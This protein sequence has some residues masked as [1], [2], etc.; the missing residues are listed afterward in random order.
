[1]EM[2][3]RQVNLINY[4]KF[5]YHW[6]E[7]A[8]FMDI[9]RNCLNRTVHGNPMSVLQMKIKRVSAILSIWSKREYGD[10][11]STVKEYEEKVRLV[12]E[13][14][15]ASNIKFNRAKLSA[16]FA[17]HIRYMKLEESVLK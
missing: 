9:V 6:T 12:E 1:M 10:I 17:E 15:L 2:E 14:I 7:N 4:F 5:L 16:I 3:F 11:F 13:E 8:S